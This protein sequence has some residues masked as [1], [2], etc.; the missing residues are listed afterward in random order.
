MDFNL[1][2]ENHS[3]KCIM[4]DRFGFVTGSYL[5]GLVWGS[6]V[7]FSCLFVLVGVVFLVFFFF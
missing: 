6:F 1:D 3:W 7:G 2:K 5:L 4:Y